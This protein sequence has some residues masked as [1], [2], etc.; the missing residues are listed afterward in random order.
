MFSCLLVFEQADDQDFGR[1]E[2][3]KLH[4]TVAM[5][6]R[7]RLGSQAYRPIIYSREK[8]FSGPNI[9]GVWTPKPSLATPRYGPSSR[10]IRS[11]FNFK[12]KFVFI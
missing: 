12:R 1:V 8:I 6:V 2:A 3:C 9:R 4:Y 10:L 7:K 5:F 11:T